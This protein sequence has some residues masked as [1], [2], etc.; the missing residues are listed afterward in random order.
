MFA[1]FVDHPMLA[2]LLT[3]W[4]AKRGA[5]PIPARREIDPL[6][7]GPA[8]LPHL[9]LCDLL[10]R[11]T[12][13]RFRL[14]G[15]EVVKRLGVDPTAKFLDAAAEGAYRDQ[16][17]SLHRL[18]YCERAPVYAESRFSWRAGRR[19][20]VLHL[21]LPLT[22]GGPDPAIALEGMIFRSG[23]A[24]APT[25]HALAEEAEYEE[26]RRV[27][28]KSLATHEWDDGPGRIVA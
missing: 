9:V 5:A 2:A 8:L 12:R 20:E 16:L 10:D 18:V 24:F 11:G 28:A 26:L 7:M 21:L 13:A 6:E 3:Y 25:I 14:V 1:S 4:R 27:V 22:Q 15:T 17:A 23:E 19:L